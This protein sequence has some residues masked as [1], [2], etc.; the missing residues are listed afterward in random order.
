MK[1]LGSLAVLALIMVFTACAEP[2]PQYAC[3][4]W[5]R[6]GDAAFPDSDKVF[7][8]VGDATNIGNK[9]LLRKTSDTRAINEIAQQL[10]ATSKSLVEDYMNSV[11]AAGGEASEQSVTQGIKTTVEKSLVG[12]KIIDRCLDPADGVHYSLAKYDL[13]RME[14]LID[15]DNSLDPKLKEYVRKNASKFFEKMEDE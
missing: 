4:E 14:K 6:K 11:S 5:S 10:N 13:D 7:Y 15:A 9:S 2:P 1:N 3:P 12:V 8:G